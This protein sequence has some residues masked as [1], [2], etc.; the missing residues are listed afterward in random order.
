MTRINFPDLTSSPMSEVMTPEM[1]E[2]Y[3]PEYES[4]G[5]MIDR[6]ITEAFYGTAPRCQVCGKPNEKCRWN[7]AYQMMLCPECPK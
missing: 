2:G 6:K 7:P 5:E 4:T 3:I 1:Q